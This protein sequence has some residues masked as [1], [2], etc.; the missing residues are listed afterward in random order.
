MRYP[1]GTNGNCWH[2]G[3]TGDGCPT[4][5]P[6]ACQLSSNANST[7]AAFVSLLGTR[8]GHIIANEATNN[9]CNAGNTTAD[10]QAE[11]TAVI[12]TNGC[13]DA[14][15]KWWTLDNEQ[16]N[17]NALTLSC[18][19]GS[20]ASC[21]KTQFATF[22]TAI[23]TVDANLKVCIDANPQH[24]GSQGSTWDTTVLATTFDCADGHYYW[25]VSGQEGDT[26]ALAAPE[27]TK[28]PQPNGC[29]VLS[30][31]PGFQGWLTTFKSDVAGSSSPSAAL[32][33][34]EYSTVPSSC[35][36]Q[37][38]SIIQTL[39]NSM[40]AGVA[41]RNN[42]ALAEFHS[43][44]VNC[45]QVSNPGSGEYGSWLGFSGTQ[46]L[47]NGVT[48]GSCNG[49]TGLPP[50]G[51]VLA[52]GNGL[53]VAQTWLSPAYNIIKFSLNDSSGDLVAYAACTSGTSGVC[54]SNGPV[55]LMLVN[56]SKDNSH[57]VTVSVDSH[58]SGTGGNIVC[59]T[60]SLFDQ[61][62]TGSW[63]GPTTTTL[64]SWTT[65]FTVTVPPW[66]VC[67]VQSG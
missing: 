38:Q 42:V 52:P 32:V 17:D 7:V 24:G 56:K 62:Q 53:E 29:G 43:A 67:S 35:S 18:T 5:G 14:K 46:S 48:T 59:Y 27:S 1:Q 57:I 40:I 20:N 64:A 23:Q 44:T 11:V 45:S 21:Y 22:R 9:A 33:V 13:S 28:T 12:T 58:A 54:T 37:C 51:T 19:P 49:T 50:A 2:V 61:S 66:S 65:S 16:Y 6:A 31:A 34:G 26:E 39:F 47:S 4:S 36:Y 3:N 63:P 10:V 60:K 8:I 25:T 15:C 41:A 30:C 55:S